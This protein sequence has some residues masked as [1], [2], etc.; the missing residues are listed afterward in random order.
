MAVVPDRRQALASQ[1]DTFDKNLSI[2]TNIVQRISTG[3]PQCNQEY[4]QEIDVSSVVEDVDAPV[5]MKPL[6]V[7]RLVDDSISQI[8]GNNNPGIGLGAIKPE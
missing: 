7:R 8:D 3:D 2:L 6:A 1:L 4:H 5:Q